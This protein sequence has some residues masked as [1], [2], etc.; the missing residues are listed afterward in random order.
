MV[1]PGWGKIE[2]GGPNSVTL[3]EAEL[4]VVKIRSCWLAYGI[5]GSTT[6]HLCTLG[7]VTDTCKVPL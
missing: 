4:Y 1:L 5:I 7:P 6:D 3:M 2:D